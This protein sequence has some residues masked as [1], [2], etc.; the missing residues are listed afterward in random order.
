MISKTSSEGSQLRVQFQ[1]SMII[2]GHWIPLLLIAGKDTSIIESECMM[3][4][5]EF[6]VI[7]GF[8]DSVSIL[9]LPYNMRP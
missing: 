6:G 1:N 8:A 9:G 5:M 4:T 3:L 7:C 2:V